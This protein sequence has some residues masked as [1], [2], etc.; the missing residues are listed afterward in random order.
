MMSMTL[1]NLGTFWL[2]SQSGLENV[3]L[4]MVDG[5]IGAY[6]RKT[7]LIENLKAKRFY[8]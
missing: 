1:F 6:E 7:A 8:L 4:D 2:F 3:N 5:K